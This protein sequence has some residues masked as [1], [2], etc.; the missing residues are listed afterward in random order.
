MRQGLSLYTVY[1]FWNY[2]M[3]KD[4]DTLMGADYVG[5]LGNPLNFPY[6]QFNL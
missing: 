5:V 1:V 4:Y 3:C 2:Y 6:F